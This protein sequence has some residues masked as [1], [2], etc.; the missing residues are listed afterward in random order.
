[1]NKCMY[2]EREGER[3]RGERD[4]ERERERE[5]ERGEREREREREGKR[6]GERDRK[7]E[8]E[9]ER[10]RDKNPY[11]IVV[12]PFLLVSSDVVIDVDARVEILACTLSL[13]EAIFSIIVP[14]QFHV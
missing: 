2:W 8:G 13:M 12:A 4:G 6:E 1:M 14:Y 11:F 3:E 7:R 10:E 9:R 5:R